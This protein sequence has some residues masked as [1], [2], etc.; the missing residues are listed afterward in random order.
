MDFCVLNSCHIVKYIN[1]F[2]TFIQI[3]TSFMIVIIIID[4]VDRGQ[5]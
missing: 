4:E 1:K 2:Q 5:A 3:K